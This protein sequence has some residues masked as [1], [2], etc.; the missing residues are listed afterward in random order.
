LGIDVL[1]ECVQVPDDAAAQLRSRLGIK[2]TES[3]RIAFVAGP[4]DAAGSFDY[5]AQGEFDPRVPIIA[6]STMFYTLIDKLRAEALVLTEPANL[7]RH[8]DPRFRFIHTP[9]QRPDGR[10]DYLVANFKFGRTVLRELRAFDPHVVIV[11]TDAPNSVLGSAPGRARVILAA[12]NTYWPMGSKNTSWM[13]ELKRSLIAKAL[14]RI[15]AAVC[16]SAECRRQ[17]EELRGRSDGLFVETPQILSRFVNGARNSDAARQLLF[18][19]RIVEAKGVFDLLDAFERV[20]ARYPEAR[21]DFAGAG[22]AAD[23][24]VRRIEASPVRGRIRFLGLLSAEQVHRALDGA[25]VMICPTRSSFFEGLAVVVIEAAVHGVPS[26]V[27]SV[28][29][30]KDLMTDACIE[31]AA[32]DADALRDSLENILADP[33]MFRELRDKTLLK[34]ATFMDRSGSWGSELCRALIC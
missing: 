12:H 9:R 28:V 25:D 24:L 34:R 31:F 18:L 2:D 15:S 19:G 22:A 32:D 5:W 20:A 23:E 33:S 26:I 27:S 13:A 16:T 21:L 30:A 7:P 6:Y 1:S 14:R 4:G 8:H 29:P 3:P 10:V 11:G 17:V